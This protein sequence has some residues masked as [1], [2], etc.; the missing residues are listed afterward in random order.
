[1]KTYIAT[2]CGFAN[3]RMIEPGEQFEYAGKPGSWM[4]A[5]DTKAPKKPKA[6]PVDKPAE[7]GTANADVI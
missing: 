2:A 1:M 4:E 6:E 3:G 5:V 7:S